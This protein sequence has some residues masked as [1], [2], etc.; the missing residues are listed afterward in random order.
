M[1][2]IAKK[3]VLCIL[4]H[5]STCCSIVSEAVGD[6]AGITTQLAATISQ[7]TLEQTWTNKSAGGRLFTFSMSA[8]EVE[9]IPGQVSAQYAV[10][11]H[12]QAAAIL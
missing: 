1:T 6:G 7:A 12:V 5:T 9:D 4:K 2:K 10:E 3:P 8:L 11:G